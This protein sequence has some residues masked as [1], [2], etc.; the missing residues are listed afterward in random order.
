MVAR[1]ISSAIKKAAKKKKNIIKIASYNKGKTKAKATKS[2]TEKPDLMTSKKAKDMVGTKGGYKTK[3]KR[4]AA[5]TK[6]KQTEFE[7]GTAATAKR[8]SIAKSP[9]GFNKIKTA[10]E[11]T[12]ANNRLRALGNRVGPLS[13]A[14]Q[15]EVKRLKKL[16]ADYERMKKAETRTGRKTQV[17]AA[18]KRRK[19]KSKITLAAPFKPK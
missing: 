17:L 8:G 18:D 11:F 6:G 14:E 13:K 2:K 5:K 1:A 7:R 19:N 16:V 10:K 3:S 12:K 4:A 15:A 9:V